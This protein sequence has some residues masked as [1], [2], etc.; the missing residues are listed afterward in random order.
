[1]QRGSLLENLEIL[2]EMARRKLLASNHYTPAIWRRV[3]ACSCK[4]FN[5]RLM[6]RA[7][8]SG[9]AANRDNRACPFGGD[10]RC[11]RT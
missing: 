1:V 9:S 5:I 3:F 6:Q 10:A 2:H 4:G 8:A 11:L 7:I